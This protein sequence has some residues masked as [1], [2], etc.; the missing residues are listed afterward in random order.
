MAAMYFGCDSNLLH[1]RR[2]IKRIGARFGRAVAMGY[3]LAYRSEVTR[4]LQ[5][6]GFLAD[7]QP[8]PEL[9]A[10][11]SHGLPSRLC[12]NCGAGTHLTDNCPLLN[13]VPPGFPPAAAAIPA[14]GPAI[15]ARLGERVVAGGA[16]D[17]CSH[18]GKK[19][20]SVAGCWSLYPDQRP[21]FKNGKKARSD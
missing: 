17:A 5:H 11:L 12:A 9:L 18:C 10:A 7:F 13:E 2:Y 19:G 20:H 15:M 21:A 3:D 1:Y 16:G 14:P 4:V 6:T 8:D